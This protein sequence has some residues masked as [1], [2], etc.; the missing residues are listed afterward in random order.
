M[1]GNISRIFDM[2]ITYKCSASHYGR[3]YCLTN[4]YY[5]QKYGM[6]LVL[7]RLLNYMYMCVCI[8]TYI[9]THTETTGRQ[10]TYVDSV[11]NIKLYYMFRPVLLSSVTRS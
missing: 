9:H 7:K 4:T 1:N 10:S 5:C 8:H 3:L 2:G 11:F 6:S